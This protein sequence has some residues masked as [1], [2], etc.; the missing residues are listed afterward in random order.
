MKSKLSVLL[1]CLIMTLLFGANIVQA[2]QTSDYRLY[3]HDK[4]YQEIVSLEPEMYSWTKSLLSDNG[5]SFDENNIQISL[6]QAIKLYSDT[7][8][9][10]INS[11]ATK[12]IKKALQSGKYIWVVPVHCEKN[13]VILTIEKGKDIDPED[14][15]TIQEILTPEQIKEIQNNIG[16]WVVNS[17]QLFPENTD[18]Y[19]DVKQ[20]VGNQ[21]ASNGDLCFVTGLPY[22]HWPIALVSD[23]NKVESIVP[24]G[25]EATHTRAALQVYSY[26]TVKERINNLPTEDKNISDG[27]TVF[28][29]LDEGIKPTSTNWK[30]I[31]VF[32]AVG[33]FILGVIILA[34]N[35]KKKKFLLKKND[36]E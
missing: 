6:N 33:T 28:Q 19:N 3:S 7:N 8:I 24:V 30:A 11:N 20:A 5:I 15:D 2:D 10:A 23:G 36:Y 21:R 31:L 35:I 16:K 9:F 14:S 26:S 32:L 4:D 25:G 18:F 12:D 1:S 29:M 13:T 34:F 22:I 17:A 27:L